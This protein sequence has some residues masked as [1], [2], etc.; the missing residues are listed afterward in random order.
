M[1]FSSAYVPQLKCQST[2][3]NCQ[4]SIW[5]IDSTLSTATTP[6]QSGPGSDGSEGIH[7]IPQSSSI[8]EASPSYGLVSY[9]GHSLVGGS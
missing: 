7:H 9:L 1:Q 8:P 3:F 4:T 5:R 2:Q 6:G